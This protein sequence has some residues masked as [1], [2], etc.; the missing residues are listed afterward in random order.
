MRVLKIEPYLTTPELSKVMNSQKSIQDFK[1]WQIIHSVQ[2]NPGKTASEIAA[3]LCVKSENIYKKVQRYNKPGVSR[4]T[5]VKRGGRRE[6]RC[7]MPL[8]KEREFLQGIEEDAIGCQ[9]VTFQQV[10]LK[11]ETRMKL[12]VS[13]DYIRDMFKRH[14]WTKKVPRQS[15]P[16][17]DRE[18]REE[19]KKNSRK[20]WLPNR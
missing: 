1:D 7:I 5:G 14:G 13:G 10:K 3:V 9:I 16:Q 19:Y 6:K 11:L 17:A 4:K 2:V 8:E 18:D 20:I 15:H 12:A